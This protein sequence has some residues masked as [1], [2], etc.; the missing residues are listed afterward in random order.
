MTR[1]LPLFAASVGAVLT[2][3]LPP[4]ASHRVI[5]AGAAGALP[6]P[7]QFIGFEV[8]ADRRLASWDAI[9]AYMELA[10]RA[11]DRIRLRHLG[12]TTE[13]R[14]FIL[15]E[16]SA[17]GTLQDLDRY[18][19]LARR[20][21][22]QGGPPTP[23]EVEE[24]ATAGKVVV[25]VTAGVHASEVGAT[26]MS[27]EL[28][29]HLATD[30]SP[31]VRKLLD[32]VILLLV[33]SA[34]PDGHAWVADWNAAAAGTPWEAG[35]LPRPTHPYAGHDI[36]RDMFMLTQ[37]ES[38]Y[39]ARVA[40]HDWFP[41]VWNDVHQMGSAGPRV[42]VMPA[43]NPINPNVHPLIYRWN[44]ILGQSQAA[45]LEAAGRHG[46]VHGTT[47]TNFWQGAMAWSGWWHNQ[48]GL[49]T[50]VASARLASPI[51]Q[52][53]VGPDGTPAA[54]DAPAAAA[55]SLLPP[56]DDITPRTEYP[57]PWLG[58]RWTLRDIVDYQLTATLGLLE[59]AAERRESILRQIYEV[60]RQTAEGADAGGVTAIVVPREDQHDP[61]Q[62][63]H[64][65]ERLALGGVE[66]YEA[67]TPFTLDGRSHGAGTFLI[68][69]AQVFG[70][71][72][73]DLLEPQVYPAIRHGPGAPIEE[74]YD[75]SAWS[76]GM[77][78][79]V[80]TIFARDPLPASVVM[81][82]VTGRPP[83][84]WS[85]TGT[86]P[87]YSFDYTGPD[88]AIAVNRLLRAGARVR[89]EGPSRVSAGAVDRTAIEAVAHAFGLKVTAGA[90]AVGDRSRRDLVLRPPRVAV[91]VPWTDRNADAGWTRWVLE[92]HEFDVTAVHDADIGGI[93]GAALSTRFDAL[94][95]PDQAPGE[96]VDGHVDG[97]VHPEYRGGIGE[98]GVEHLARFV[99][100]GGTLVTLGAASHLA[101][102]RLDLPV[103]DVKRLLRH[104]EHGAPGSVLHLEIDTS[105]PLGHGMA[106]AT[107]G[108]YTNGPILTVTDSGKRRASVVA[109][110]P[111]RDVLASGR[112]V[113]S[114]HMAGRAAVVSVETG[115]GRVVL[116]AIRPQHRAQTE[117]TFPLLFNALY[118]SVAQA[119]DAMPSQ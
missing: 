116:F 108:F 76:L 62:A 37:K 63:A 55:G 91:Y 2:L 113:G 104:D 45:A 19:Q 114:G 88:S 107:F 65:V 64:L 20:L 40:W 23:A 30:E 78:F 44:A 27:L 22:F 7:E 117:A 43:T 70:R 85:V 33:P 6:P 18:K 61:R 71:Y 99:A 73:R 48:I 103:R 25:L 36:N 115:P 96:M 82:R 13:G 9:V 105:H 56:P 32:H 3:A 79:G 11:S 74:P 83:V 102:D 29:H 109:R 106:P 111:A 51:E 87:R 110:Y 67:A 60:N 101:I 35:P 42:F 46:I 98:T 41:A 80:R 12:P 77:Q 50:E 86:A 119:A 10:A 57:R 97:P 39:V 59:A 100:A 89:F 93:A 38:Q 72:A 75:V 26:Q 54:G 90:V 53:R 94:I 15:L 4:L 118:A 66:I 58:G 68:P 92:R 112:L 17:P 21:Y 47:Y 52:R 24:I 31:R 84:K 34:N 16:I 1:V 8:G 49:L 28:V 5:A 14:P 81:T 69:M 95:L